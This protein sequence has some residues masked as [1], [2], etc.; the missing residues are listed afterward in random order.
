MTGSK[1]NMM[2]RDEVMAAIRAI[3]PE[4][5]FVWDGIDEDDRPATAEELNAALESYRRKRGR[6][7]GSTKTQITLRID[8]ET[9]AA[10]R[11]TGEGWQ[12][13]MNEALRD[14]IKSHS[15]A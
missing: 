4:Q 11:A 13:R 10:F 2:T 9:L 3:P 15:P 12:T 6:P 14:W 8:N 7:T 1:T 5:D